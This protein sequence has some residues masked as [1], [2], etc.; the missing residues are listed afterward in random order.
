MIPDWFLE[1]EF[2][3]DVTKDYFSHK[4]LYVGW[5]ELYSKGES[6]LYTD[7]FMLVK[8]GEGFSYLRTHLNEWSLTSLPL[9]RV[10]NENVEL[11]FTEF[12][13]WTRYMIRAI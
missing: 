4:N 5:Y 12:L 7:K 8:Q 3:C 13:A 9:E 10:M 6:K 2:Q 11:F 1:T